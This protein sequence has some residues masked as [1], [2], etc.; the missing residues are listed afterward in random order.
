MR[1]SARVDLPW[2]M[3]AMIEKLRMASMVRVVM[4]GPI[5]APPPDGNEKLGAQGCRPTGGEGA[6][7]LK[8]ERL[9]PARRAFKS[10]RRPERRIAAFSSPPNT[11]IAATE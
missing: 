10:L 6:Y 9:R 1:R 4:R 2:S 7:P 8:N 5:A 3:W 11:K